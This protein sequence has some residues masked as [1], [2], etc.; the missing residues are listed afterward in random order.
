[1][2]VCYDTDMTANLA[3]KLIKHNGDILSRYEKIVPTHQHHLR[4]ARQMQQKILVANEQPMAK[5]LHCLGIKVTY[6]RD[7]V[8]RYGKDN[9]E[10]NPHKNSI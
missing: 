5:S 8:I 6:T 9:P 3:R 4:N 1:M 2:S 10:R 7:A